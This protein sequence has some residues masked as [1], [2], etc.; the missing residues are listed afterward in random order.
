MR[1]VSNA[2]PVIH[3]SWI[4]RLDILRALFDK[5]LV[6]LAVRD[7]VLRAGANVPGIQDIRDAFAANWLSAQPIIAV[8]AVP[9][10]AIEL[11]RGEAE[12]IVLMREI[13]ADLLLLDDRRA[14]ARAA[15]EGL[16]ITGTI[17]ILQLARDRG[18]VPAVAPLLE[19]LQRRGFWISAELV[20]RIQQDEG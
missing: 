12:A 18:I 7:E 19:E 4:G 11:D 17:G 13:R 20:E 1:A 6:P 15:G 3:L 8:A 16:R 5:V 10:L 9:P 2:G 14:R